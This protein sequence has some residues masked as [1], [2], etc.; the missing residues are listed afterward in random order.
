MGGSFFCER[1]RVASIDIDQIFFPSI[2]TRTTIVP[3]GLPVEQK[4]D[5]P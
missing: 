3:Y 4:I 5:P 1:W 2:V